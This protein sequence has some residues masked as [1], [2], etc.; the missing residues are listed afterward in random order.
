MRVLQATTA[1]GWSGG[2]EQALLLAKYMNALGVETHLLTYPETEL[3][4]RAKALGIKTVYFPNSKRFSLREAKEL[5]ALLSQYSVVNTHISK[6]HW[7]VWLASLVGGKP[8]KLI[9]TRRVPYRLS[10]LSLLTKYNLR[11]DW[12]IAVSPQIYQYLKGV[13]FVKEKVSFIPSGVELDRFNPE[14][15]SDFRE[16]LKVPRSALVFTN[17]GNFSEVKGHHLLLPAF[18]KLLEEERVNAYLV[19]VG[20]DTDSERCSSLIR[21][22]GLEGRVF[23]LGFRRDVPRILAG[24]DVFV[25]PSLN[26]GIAGSLIQAMAM[27]KVVVASFVGGIKSYLK[28]GFNG[29]AVKPGNLESLYAGM[30]RALKHLSD[31][32]MRERARETAV[33]FDIKL[34]AEKTLKVYEGVLN[35]SLS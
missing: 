26:E 7:F 19:L 25:F 14:L 31:F 2:T 23:A 30:K 24:T 10:F 29:L 20:R 35:G 9:Y 6:A 11:T 34:I 4:R 12:L 8:F 15:P 21:K 18:K 13:P 5:A 33:N 16:E 32:A 22:W 3:D 1:R 28:D 17:V 27:K